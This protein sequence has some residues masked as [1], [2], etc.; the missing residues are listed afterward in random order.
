MRNFLF[1]GGWI[2]LLL[3]PAAL[4]AFRL[5]DLQNRHDKPKDPVKKEAGS[6]QRL[7]G[8]LTDAGLLRFDTTTYRIELPAEDEGLLKKALAGSGKGDAE[9]ADKVARLV[10]LLY[11]SNSGK[12][13]VA[14]VGQWN[15]AHHLAAVRAD[16][17]TASHQPAWSA[18]GNG[19]SLTVSSEVPLSLGFINHPARGV[20]EDMGNW[21]AATPDAAGQVVHMKGLFAVS[22][23]RN[24]KLQVIGTPKKITV[25]GSDRPDLLVRRDPCLKDTKEE[26]SGV[27]SNRWCATH[28]ATPTPAAYVSFAG[29]PLRPGDNQIEID[30]IPTS[31]TDER[32]GGIRIW[33][34]ENQKLVWQDFEP[35]KS[36]PARF[37]ILAANGNPLTGETG[38]PNQRAVELGVDRIIGPSRLVTYSLS[39]RLAAK[40]SPGQVH[41]V[42]LTIDPKWQDAATQSM[43]MADARHPNSRR[44]ASVVLMD[45]ATGDL[46]AVADQQHS[47]PLNANP[48][49]LMSFQQVYPAIGPMSIHA[50]QSGDRQ[51]TPGSTFKLLSGLAIAQAANVKAPEQKLVQKLV[52][53]VT[54]DEIEDK[55]GLGI[56]RS[57]PPYSKRDFSY[58]VPKMGDTYPFHNDESKKVTESLLDGF[59]KKL[60]NRRL[61]E[62]LGLCEAT[63]ES[64]NIWFVRMMEIV[65]GK[66]L[67][68]FDGRKAGLDAR[69]AQ[70]IKLRDE[71]KLSKADQA[72]LDAQY[73]ALPV[74]ETHFTGIL[75]ALNLNKIPGQP[76]YDLLPG[77]NMPEKH[78]IYADPVSSFLLKDTALDLANRKGVVLTKELFFNSYGQGV[79]ATP[80]AISQLAA[81]VATGQGITPRLVKALDGKTLHIDPKQIPPLNLDGDVLEALRDGMKAVPEKGT[82]KKP[83]EHAKN[84]ASIVWAKTGTANIVS[85]EG[86]PEPF[87]TGWLAGWVDDG[88]SK[89]AF[90]CMVTHWTGYGAD[91]C[92]PIIIDILNRYGVAVAPA[93]VPVNTTS[94]KPQRAK[95]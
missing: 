10:K 86:N 47:L 69:N 56:A 94:S 40:L 7:L 26:L 64:F 29:V 4:L 91:A 49:D 65:D 88:K 85:K 92:A 58:Y 53:G 33:R 46:L 13:I 59:G 89:V 52:Q 41:S 24:L 23:A 60:C 36:D 72:L 44:I 84:L 14:E 70:L 81:A 42:T 73:Q 80:L 54:K 61:G 15:A 78:S 63:A 39:G 27:L 50:W 74:P 77:L 67:R 22:T 6:A 95:K 55:L 1:R 83:F 75:K 71:N 18:W 32:V 90:A 62:K 12:A 30:L 43:K 38:I 3:L 5:A 76:G 11:N 57:Y 37:S 2:L 45:V 20:P 17:T 51:F 48:W 68:E 19:L 28:R 16:Y 34:D 9:Q 79:T 25:N 87:H 82:A 21:V 66:T 93:P 31:V 8:K 35:S